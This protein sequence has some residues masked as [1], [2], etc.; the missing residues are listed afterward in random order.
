MS[1]VL[2]GEFG[3]GDHL[4]DVAK[5]LIE[6]A[7]QGTAVLPLRAG[8]LGQAGSQD[9]GIAAREEHR[10]LDSAFGELIAIGFLNPGN[11]PM[12][13]KASQIVTHATGRQGLG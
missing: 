6:R 4:V 8:D 10:Y 11:E 9:A 13:A 12:E 3:I 5:D 2:R 7:T 1:Q